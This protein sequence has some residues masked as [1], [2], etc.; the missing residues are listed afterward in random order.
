MAYSFDYFLDGDG[1]TPFIS[2][3]KKHRSENVS[4]AVNK[5]VNNCVNGTQKKRKKKKRERRRDYIEI[6]TSTATCD[7]ATFQSFHFNFYFDVF[8]SR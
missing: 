4:L 7:E 1:D 6:D 3:L 2:S 5:I 8:L